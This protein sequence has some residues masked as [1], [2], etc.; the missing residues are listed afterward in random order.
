MKDVNKVP[1]VLLQRIT[2]RI[3]DDIA[4]PIC[5]SS[6]GDKLLSAYGELHDEIEEIKNYDGPDNWSIADCAAWLSDR[7]LLEEVGEWSGVIV[8]PYGELNSWM[9]SE[10]LAD[11]IYRTLENAVMQD[12]LLVSVTADENGDFDKKAWAKEAWSLLSASDRNV[13]EGVLL[14]NVESWA[15]DEDGWRDAVRDI[16]ECPEVY[17]WFAMDDR[18]TRALAEEGEVVMSAFN[19]DMWGRQ[20]AGQAIYMDYVIQKVASRWWGRYVDEF[21]EIKGHL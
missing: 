7:D 18:F 20:C 19:L 4:H 3:L 15:E 21:P 13:I 14:D 6:L 12:N 2:D 16:W 1:S 8:D 5:V 9:R 11:E 10:D 17:Q